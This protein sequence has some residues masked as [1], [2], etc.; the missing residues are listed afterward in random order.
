MSYQ[1]NLPGQLNQLTKPSIYIARWS[2]NAEVYLN[3]YLIHR[4]GSVS[5]S[6]L[7]RY[8]HRPQLIPLPLSLLQQGDNTLQIRLYSAYVGFLSAVYVGEFET[9]AAKHELRTFWQVHLNEYLF[10]LTLG[11]GVFIFFL[12]SLKPLARNYLFAS[13]ACCL[14]A[15][16]L[17]GLAIHSFTS[18]GR[19]PLWALHTSMDAMLLCLVFFGKLFRQPTG[20]LPLKGWERAAIF[21]FLISSTLYWAVPS[22]NLVATTS[23][24]HGLGVG[25]LTVLA[26]QHLKIGKNPG[27]NQQLLFAS[28]LAVFIF[29]YWYDVYR[30]YALNTFA[31]ELGYDL[32]PIGGTFILV[33]IAWNLA[34]R[35]T[36]TMAKSEYLSENLQ[37][38][39]A[40]ARRKLDEEFEQRQK[41][42]IESEK[43]SVRRGIYRY[44]HEEIGD[45]LVA[46]L[47]SSADE[48]QEKLAQLALRDLREAFRL[49]RDETSNRL[50][51]ILDDCFA[52]ASR[53]CEEF[54]MQLY[55]Q[56]CLDSK[57]LPFLEPNLAI[58]LRRT[59]REAMSNTFKH[60]SAS[61][62]HIGLKKEQDVL[63]LQIADNGVGLGP[64]KTIPSLQAR[65]TSAHGIIEIQSSAVEGTRLDISFPLDTS[66]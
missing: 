64:L 60:A 8:S 53:R 43:I 65:V 41:R 62:L 49:S 61:T 40:A 50:D 42:S 21:W 63:R 48:K 3:G 51:L 47:H 54:G 5:E 38:E 33:I 44:L 15:I 4:E 20:G 59:I 22:E 9:L 39:V 25:L 31:S 58:S 45:K 12:W 66:A 46:L 11:M 27:D 13:A 18:T 2:D 29:F 37:E 35:F 24:T 19:L 10:A 28:S 55:W 14:W 36:E 52:E 1:I 16:Y 26:F 34:L 30:D 56:G 57:D 32:L 6:A 17:H 23:V 7:S